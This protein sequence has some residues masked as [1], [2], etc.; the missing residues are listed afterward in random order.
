MLTFNPEE[1]ISAIQCL[2]HPFFKNYEDELD[3]S[4]I[5]KIK[6]DWNWDN[7]ALSRSKL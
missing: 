3:G 2:E 4:H 7:F 6:F 1:R 5:S